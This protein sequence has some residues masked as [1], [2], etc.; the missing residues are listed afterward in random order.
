MAGQISKR[1]FQGVI[2][3]YG[4]TAFSAIDTAITITSEKLFREAARNIAIYTPFA[5]MASGGLGY[6]YNVWGWI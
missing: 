4:K 5:N 3:L 1:G 2:N 6:L